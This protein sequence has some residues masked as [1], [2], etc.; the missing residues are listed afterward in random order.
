MPS[1]DTQ[2]KKGQKGGPGRPKG[3]L[4]KTTLAVQAL[5]DGEAEAIG[6]KAVE[7]ALN[8]DST[9]LRLCMER[10][11][12][13]VKERPINGFEIPKINTQEDVLSAIALVTECLAKGELLPSESAAICSVLDQY[14]RHYETTEFEKRLAQ[15]E[16]VMDEKN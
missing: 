8:G 2:F 15:L 9:A 5:F 3:A 13:P 10:I 12:P 6:R 14:R 4:N 7:M 11:A 16:E 1:E